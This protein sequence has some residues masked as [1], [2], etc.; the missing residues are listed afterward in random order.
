MLT[1]QD[2]P[3]LL[4]LMVDDDPGASDPRSPG[5][6]WKK[7]SRHLIQSMRNKGLGEYSSFLTVV[8]RF[9]K[10]ENNVHDLFLKWK[11][12][13]SLKL[14]DKLLNKEIVNQYFSS[15]FSITAFSPFVNFSKVT[16]VAEIGG[17]SGVFCHSLLELFPNIKKYIYVDIPPMLYLAT[18]N[19]RR[20]YGTQVVDYRQTRSL[21]VISPYNRK[22]EIFM[23]CPWQTD[24]LK[25]KVD[26]F[27][28]SIA[29][30]RMSPKAVMSYV[31]NLKKIVSPNQTKI[32]LA[33]VEGPGFLK[34][35]SPQEV[36][37]LCKSGIGYD[38]KMIWSDKRRGKGKSFFL[39]TR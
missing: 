4:E 21:K 1:I 32:G 7:K 29:F 31:E 30:Q 3:D 34:D 39:G 6:L 14:Q 36:I 16:A 35:L 13:T 38:F 17:G 12:M 22:R 37:Q 11:R 5:G 28:N 10:S 26:F 2:D 20:F 15:F 25:V 9:R 19:L 33:F 24:R 27:W 18:C 8:D 23:I